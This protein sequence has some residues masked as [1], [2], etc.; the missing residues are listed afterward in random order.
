[1]MKQMHGYKLSGKIKW[2]SGK[3]LKPVW[4]TAH[5]ES[6]SP[7]N[8]KLYHNKATRGSAELSSL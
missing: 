4:S 8:S 3:I 1:M 5:E 2:R 6:K 7:E